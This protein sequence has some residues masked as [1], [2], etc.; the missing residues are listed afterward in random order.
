VLR[1]TGTHSA[2]LQATAHGTTRALEHVVNSLEDARGAFSE[3]LA[4]VRK[5]LGDLQ[6]QA[7]VPFEHG[8]RL[9]EL[10]K[11]QQELVQAL[12]LSRPEVQIGITSDT[13]VLASA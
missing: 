9:A 2:R 3:R 8:A 1:G 10:E 13:E 11:R 7:D 6:V 5:Q 12:D 4:Q